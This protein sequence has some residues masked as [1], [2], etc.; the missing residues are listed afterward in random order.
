[1]NL[2]NFILNQKIHLC[3]YFSDRCCFV[4]SSKLPF[5]KLLIASL[6]LMCSGCPKHI[7]QANVDNMMKYFADGTI[8]LGGVPTFGY[9]HYREKMKAFYATSD[10]ES[11]AKAVIEGNN[12]YDVDWYY[13]GRSAEGLGLYKAAKIYYTNALLSTV[14]KCRL[15]DVIP[16]TECEGLKFLF[17]DVS[18]CQ[19]PYNDCEG[20]VFPQDITVRLNA[21]R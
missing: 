8:K 20:F 2:I 6:I 7:D 21:L 12:N 10:W 13:L 16:F 14:D 15:V 1:M 3:N 4:R 18:R 19:T 9:G 17:Q 11:L 5:A